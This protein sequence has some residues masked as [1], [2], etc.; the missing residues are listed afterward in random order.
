MR[1]KSLSNFWGAFFIKRKKK[2]DKKYSILN[3]RFK[4]DFWAFLWK[5]GGQ[6][7]YAKNEKSGTSYI[8][9]GMGM[10]LMPFFV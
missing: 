2:F 9:R 4:W 5:N 6:G 8:L 3:R 7:R 10:Q 1:P